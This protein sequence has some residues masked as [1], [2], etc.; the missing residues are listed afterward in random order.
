MTGVCFSSRLIKLAKP[1]SVSPL[2]GV[3]NLTIQ[4]RTLPDDLK[5]AQGH[6]VSKRVILYEKTLSEKISSFIENI[7]DRSLCAVRRGHG[8]QTTLLR[9]L[10]DWIKRGCCSAYGPF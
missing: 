2:T 7:F 4:K 1:A 8:C 10:E 9:L 6:H 5:N 3:V